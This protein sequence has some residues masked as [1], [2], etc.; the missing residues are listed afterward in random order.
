MMIRYAVKIVNAGDF[1][2]YAK[3]H[4]HLPLVDVRED[5]RFEPVPDE[6][7]PLIVDYG[8]HRRTPQ[9]RYT[10]SSR[11]RPTASATDGCDSRYAYNR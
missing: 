11:A 5:A 9:K 4:V 6:I 3:T 10:P 8:I 2:A 1:K 7:V